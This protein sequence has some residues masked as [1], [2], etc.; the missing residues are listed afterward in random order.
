MIAREHL[1]E[2]ETTELEARTIGRLIGVEREAADPKY[3][4]ALT[5]AD[6]RHPTATAP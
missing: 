4:E 5:A 6:A 2:L 1:A 3:I